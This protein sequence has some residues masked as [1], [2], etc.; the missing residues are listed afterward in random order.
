[1]PV[2]VEPPELAR[3]LDFAERPRADEWSLRQV[4]NPHACRPAFVKTMRVRIVL[5]TTRTTRSS[6]R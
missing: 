3:L 4:S 1:M 2:E 6:P 5:Q